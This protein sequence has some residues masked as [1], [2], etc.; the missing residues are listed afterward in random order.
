MIPGDETL[1]RHGLGQGVFVE[2]TVFSFEIHDDADGRDHDDDYDQRHDHGRDVE[3]DGDEG[4][5]T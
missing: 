4:L 5:W 2:K 1:Q 3:K